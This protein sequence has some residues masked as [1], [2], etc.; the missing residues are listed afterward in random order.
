[1]FRTSHIWPLALAAVVL[2]ACS[3]SPEPGNPQPSSA[4]GSSA[5]TSSANSALPYAGAPQ[6]ADPLPVSILSGDP[7]V[8]ALTADQTRTIFG[9]VESGGRSDHGAL[10]PTCGWSNLD[11]GASLLVTYDLTHDG[12]SSVYRGS[13]PRATVWREVSTQSFPAVAYVTDLG[14]SKDAFCAISVGVADS[15]TVDIGLTLSRAK[16]GKSDPCAVNAQIADLVI[17]NLRQKAGS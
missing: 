13:K 7:C 4:A 1:M 2:A 11:S 16:V 10:G 17:G 15:A 6:V 8:D 5:S 12:L 3:N 14:G 9:Q